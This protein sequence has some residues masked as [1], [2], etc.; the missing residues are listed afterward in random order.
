VAFLDS[1]NRWLPDHLEV[2]CEL[3]RRHPEAVAA[4]TC[5]DFRTYGRDSLAESR[6]VDLLPGLTIGTHVGFISCVAARRSALCAM[7]GFD[8]RLAVWEDSDLFLRLAM[9]GPFCVLARRTIVRRTSR[10]GLREQGIRSGRYLDAM[11]L[12]AR[13][14]VRGLAGLDRPDL[15][16]LRRSLRARVTLI[17]GLRAA[18][19]GDHRRA[20]LMLGRACRL[21]PDF[22]T[23]PGLV[24]GTLRHGVSDNNSLFRAAATTARAWP[25]TYSDTARFLALC[26][27]ALAARRHRRRE[28]A[29]WLARS[30]LLTRPMLLVRTRRLTSRLLR[31]WL[32]KSSQVLRVGLRVRGADAKV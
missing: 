29:Y 10:D 15:P 2:V 13:C 5:P 1:D 32:E 31:E 9:L 24:L 23:R 27:A 17:R 30:Q 28:A 19:Q 8:E 14:A 6:V 25:D 18:I 16:A 26:A 3:L 22:S 21:R 12:S 4:S 11:E 20:G 7:G